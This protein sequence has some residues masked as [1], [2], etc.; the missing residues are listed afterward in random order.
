MRLHSLRITAFGPFAGT[1][2]VDFDQ[3]ATSGL[4]LLHGQ[5][6]AGKTSVLDAVCYAL[7][8][9]VPGARQRGG[10]LRSDHA[11]GETGPEVQLELTVRDRR[12]RIT[13]SPAWDRPKRRGSGTTPEQ[14]RT[15]VEA[16]RN[17]RW[18]TL[19]TRND[20]AGQLVHDLTGMSAEQFCQV[21]L[22]PQGA[23]ADFL[24][25]GAEERR[26]LL[27][28]LF[29]T[30][31]FSDVE[32]WLAERRRTTRRTVEEGEQRLAQLVARVAEVTG[33]QPPDEQGPATDGGWT[34]QHWVQ[35]LQNQAEGLLVESEQRLRTA[36][37]TRDAARVSCQEAERLAEAQAE[38]GRARSRAAL[39]DQEQ[40]RRRAREAELVAA[41][42]AAPVAALLT[43]AATAADQ[44]AGAV[45]AER[46]ARAD[47]AEYAPELT[48]ADLAALRTA[49]AETGQELARLEELSATADQQRELARAVVALESELAALRLRAAEL[50][51]W[52]EALPVR[53]HE[54]EQAAAAEPEARAAT[55]R[56]RL[57]LAEARRQQEAATERDRLTGELAADRQRLR[58]A[59]DQA[60]AARE[61]WLGLRQRRLDGM[62]A[63]L[64]SSLRPGEHCP[65]C[66]SADHPAPARPAEGQVTLVAEQNAEESHGTA[67]QHRARAERAV[68]EVEAEL[69][70][71][72]ERA[73]GD[74]NAAVLAE[75]TA[76]H[77]AELTAASAHL[78]VAEE[79][80]FAAEQLRAEQ[81]D[82][83]QTQLT[84]REGLSATEERLAATGRR[85]VEL[86][87][88]VRAALGTDPDLASRAARL[89][90]RSAAAQTAVETVERSRSAASAA[91][92]ALEAAETAAVAA[93]FADSAAVALA[94]RDPAATTKLEERVRADAAE[95]TALAQL[96][97]DPRLVE[98]GS[99]P[100][101][102]PETAGQLLTAAD[103]RLA[104]AAGAH[105][106]AASVARSLQRLAGQLTEWVQ[107]H[108]PAL[109][110]HQLVDRLSRLCEG[111]SGENTLRMRLSAY[112]LAARLEQ[113]A[114]AATHRLAGMSGGRYQ[115]VHSDAAGGRGRSGLGLRVRDAWTGRDRDTTTLS[116][117]ESFFA[118][119]ALA[120]GLA[121]VVSA[122]AGGILLET[123]FVDEG[124]G[125]LDETTLDEVMDV[126][127]GLREGGRTVGLVSHVPELRQRISTQV[128]VEKGR[129]GSRITGQT[130]PDPGSFG[131]VRDD[132]SAPT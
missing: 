66:G 108:A 98:A 17:G 39:L 91:A 114:E 106:A 73:G 85:A 60:Q 15:L 29:A 117:G 9:V 128:L 30:G 103:Q 113:V 77:A 51:N 121:D 36:T 56:A 64:A 24:R 130:S 8:A 127:D 105:T 96:L 111:T 74:E 131:R 7:Y 126:L 53:Q 76:R 122:E 26:P 43:A 90:A 86:A 101:A 67:E 100:A 61:H 129:F 94:S 46:L 116:G 81:A 47:L 20:E 31:R 28:R 27:E 2:R 78:T 52:F 62:A 33:E 99:A 16:E 89:T 40:S 19:T 132:G 54:V 5:T 13:R 37:A 41:R 10:R 83:Q 71:A 21:V 80:R 79:A 1:E 45:E 87:D 68:A 118:S 112:V 82:R 65:V 6:G 42:A 35:R 25:A 59:V 124:F 49:V 110:E 72:R 102:D 75:Q 50:D 70:A 44:A 95:A 14:A 93:G 32:R 22:L 92:T 55:E 88:S 104:E 125:S 97:A 115:L 109:A 4:F 38:Y 58:D 11:A 120:L 18:Q 119:L 63:E 57:R 48:G 3:L 34:H 123:L 12:L 107:E 84:V 23:F 69:A